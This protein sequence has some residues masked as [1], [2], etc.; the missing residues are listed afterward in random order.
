MWALVAF[1][2]K[3]VPKVFWEVSQFINWNFAGI[4]TYSDS[5][6]TLLWVS[7]SRSSNSLHLN[8]GLIWGF[9]TFCTSLSSTGHHPR[10][11]MPTISKI[12]G[13]LLRI[14][15]SCKIVGFLLRIIGRCKNC[16]IAASNNRKLRIFCTLWHFL[17]P[18]ATAAD[19]NG[20]HRENWNSN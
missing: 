17:P 1:L 10:D 4:P 14:I 13:L 18:L 19:L 15:R 3:K 16:W 11:F 6:E 8:R 12:V 9:Q 2:T 7:E 5:F 20:F